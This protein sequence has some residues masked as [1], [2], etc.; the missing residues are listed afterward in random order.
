MYCPPPPLLG[1]PHQRD[2]AERPDLHAPG[3]VTIML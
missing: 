3:Q 1:V 2:R